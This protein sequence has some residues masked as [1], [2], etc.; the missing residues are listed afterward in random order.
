MG[1]R[2]DSEKGCEV[3]LLTLTHIALERKKDPFDMHIRNPI[4]Q[5]V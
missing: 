3:Y 4:H 5:K 2:A 1:S